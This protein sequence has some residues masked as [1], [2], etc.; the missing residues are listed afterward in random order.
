MSAFT[1]KTL[2]DAYIQLTPMER[3]EFLHLLGKISVAEVPWVIVSE[4]NE[5]EAKRF[6]DIMFS[7]IYW[8]FYPSLEREARQM[9]RANPGMSDEEFEKKFHEH[10]KEQKEHYDHELSALATAQLKA[11]RDRKSDPEIILRNVKI[12]DLRKQDK[13]KWSQGRLAKEFHVTARAIRKIL[14]EEQ[15]WRRMEAQLR[16]K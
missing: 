10:I 4:F 11:S 14:H 6:S 3:N 12:C 16:T 8:R 5:L 1:P 13:R 2:C 9:A 15:K 7:E